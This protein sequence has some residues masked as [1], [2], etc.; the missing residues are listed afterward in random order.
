MLVNWIKELFGKDSEFLQGTSERYL[1]TPTLTEVE[2]DKDS[3]VIT[4]HYDMKT[5]DINM[6]NVREKE[7]DRVAISVG[8]SATTATVTYVKMP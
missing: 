7:L 6:V 5:F 8:T 2:D 4:E 1:N 3:L